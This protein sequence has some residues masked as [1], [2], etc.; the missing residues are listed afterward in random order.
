MENKPIKEYLSCFCDTIVR[1]HPPDEEIFVDAFIKGLKE[2]PFNESLIRN[3]D[4]NMTNV[5]VIEK[6]QHYRNT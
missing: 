2:N 3:K 1:I 5:H 6:A 4:E